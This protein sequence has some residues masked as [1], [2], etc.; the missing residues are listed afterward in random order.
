MGGGGLDGCTRRFPCTAH[1]EDV[2]R[3]TSEMM[4]SIFA[5][6]FKWYAYKKI[7]LNLRNGRVEAAVAG[8]WPWRIWAA[9]V[10]GRTVV[11]GL[12]CR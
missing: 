11:G 12:R 2:I 7:R 6:F 4:A 9:L 8:R 3:E 5:T 1:E 10:D